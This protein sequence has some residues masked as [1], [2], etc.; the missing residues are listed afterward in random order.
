[1]LLLFYGFCFSGQ[2]VCGIL[3]PQPEIESAPPALEG[4]A[5]TMGHQGSPL[6]VLI[7]HSLSPAKAQFV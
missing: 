3:A 1:M 4:G 6:D 5:L 2:E 7:C